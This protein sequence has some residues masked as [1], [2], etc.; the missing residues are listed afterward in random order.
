MK[1]FSKTL[2]KYV[3]ILTERLLVLSFREF[4]LYAGVISANF[5]FFGKFYRSIELLTKAKTK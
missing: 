3:R 2:D 1:D 4:F 5:R